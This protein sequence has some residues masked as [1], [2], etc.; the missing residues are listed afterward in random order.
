MRK[1]KQYIR[2]AKRY[3]GKSFKKFNTVQLLIIGQDQHR[4][5]QAKIDQL[6]NIK[7]L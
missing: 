7:K 4:Q 2:L 5:S 3:L 6:F 1:E